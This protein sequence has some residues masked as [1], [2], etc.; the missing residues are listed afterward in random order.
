MR[1]SN[2]VMRGHPRASWKERTRPDPETTSGRASDVGAV[3]AHAAREAV[4]ETGD[5][6]E[7]GR[8]AGAIGADQTGDGACRNGEGRAVESPDAAET[9]PDIV[10]LKQRR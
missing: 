3:D 6:I 7:N 4:D 9:R 8:L 10:H 1:C 5:A 2:I